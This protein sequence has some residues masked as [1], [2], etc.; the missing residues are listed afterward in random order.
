MAMLVFFAVGLIIFQFLMSYF[1]WHSE[2]LS[3]Y[4]EYQQ[5]YEDYLNIEEEEFVGLEEDAVDEEN[6]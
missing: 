3:C 1:I 2:G 6:Y 4:E 5:Y